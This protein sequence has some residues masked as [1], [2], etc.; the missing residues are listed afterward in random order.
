VSESQHQDE[1]LDVL[2]RTQPD[3]SMDLKKFK[4]S[5][6]DVATLPD[7]ILGRVLGAIDNE[8]LGMALA[9]C[10]EDV[11]EVILDAVSEKRKAMLAGQLPLY[12]GAPKEKLHAAKQDLTRRIREVLA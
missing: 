1:L 9:G 8:S 4:F 7:G 10:S 6:E 5:L 2:E 3:I 11:A 12:R